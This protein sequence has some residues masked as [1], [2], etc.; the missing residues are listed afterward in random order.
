MI[1][2]PVWIAL[3]AVAAVVWFV[4]RRANE[5]CVLRLSPEG[6]RLV[7]GRAPA[8]FL[9]DAT[10]VARRAALAEATVR[11]VTESGEPRVLPAPGVPGEV[12]QQLRNIAGQY[13]VVHFRTGRRAA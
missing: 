1:V 12:A 10:E 8:R 9:S 7:R 13:R 11:V 3:A 2:D 5:L 6:A 4:L